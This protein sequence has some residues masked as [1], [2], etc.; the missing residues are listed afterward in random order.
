MKYKLTKTKKKNK[1][2][3]THDALNNLERK[4]KKQKICIKSQTIIDHLL[5][6]EFKVELDKKLVKIL[7]YLSDEEDNADETLLLFDELARLRSILY[8]DQRLSKEITMKYM[9]KIRLIAYELKKR[10]ISYKTEQT[11]TKERSRSIWH[12]SKHMVIY[13]LT[14]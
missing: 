2:K 11:K 5:L 7:E 10:L 3:N 13:I 1:A 6:K 4:I 12:K 14:F 9:K 8:E